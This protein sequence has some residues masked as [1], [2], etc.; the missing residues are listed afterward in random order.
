[1]KG[2]FDDQFYTL[3]Q[4]DDLKL[5][6][7]DMFQQNFNK[8]SESLQYDENIKPLEIWEGFNNIELTY[9]DPSQVVKTISQ[10]E[11]GYFGP[12]TGRTSTKNLGETFELTPKLMGCLANFRFNTHQ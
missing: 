5:T 3:D 9:N 7:T 10:D 2:Y 11:G 12:K 4:H 6:V 8:I 1:M